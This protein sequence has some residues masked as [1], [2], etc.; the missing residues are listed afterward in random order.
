MTVSIMIEDKA[1]QKPGRV[2]MFKSYSFSLLL[3]NSVML[4]L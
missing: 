2:Q 3:Y 4:Q 1:V